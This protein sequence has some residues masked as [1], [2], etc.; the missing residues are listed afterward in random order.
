LFFARNIESLLKTFERHA[1][2]SAA[3]KARK[4]PVTTLESNS[5]PQATR[6]Q[7][8]YETTQEEAHRAMPDG[9]DQFEGIRRRSAGELGTDT[10]ARGTDDFRALERRAYDEYGLTDNIR[11]GR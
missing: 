1:G 4:R 2:S 8:A 11:M 10:T 5:L 9:S 7:P 3:A 6:L